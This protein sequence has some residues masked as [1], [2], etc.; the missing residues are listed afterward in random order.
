MT[1]VPSYVEDALLVST[2]AAH[3][4]SKAENYSPDRATSRVV[5]E[6]NISEKRI[7]R[8]IRM[9]NFRE[10]RQAHLWLQRFQVSDTVYNLPKRS[11]N[12]VLSFSPEISWLSLSISSARRV[13]G[14]FSIDSP[15]AF[16]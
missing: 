12:P 9:V 16:T 2:V 1:F 11:R 8:Y 13:F 6:A 14:K 15:R 7:A 5:V 4:S 10:G 3:G